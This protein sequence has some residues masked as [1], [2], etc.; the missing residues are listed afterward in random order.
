MAHVN[1]WAI[2]LGFLV[3]LKRPP[4]VNQ[5]GSKT[6]RVYCASFKKSKPL[7]EMYTGLF[8]QIAS[9]CATTTK[10]QQSQNPDAPPPSANKSEA[11]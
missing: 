8:S 4:K 3:K 7:D 10:F 2:S 11:A 6:L 5:D 1:I 9:R